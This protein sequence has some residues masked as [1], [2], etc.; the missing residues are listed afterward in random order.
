MNNRKKPCAQSYLEALR[1][2]L[3]TEP[4]AHQWET[5]VRSWDAS[6]YAFFLEMGTGKSKILLDSIR[7]LSLHRDLDGALIVAPKGTYANWI[8][9]EI[10]RHLDGTDVRAVLWQG[11]G[12]K[13]RREELASIM[14][15]TTSVRL[16]V[17]NTEA[18]STK[19]GQ[20]VADAFLRSCRRPLMA[21]DE[22]TAIKNPQ[23]RRTKAAI[24]LG[25]KAEWTR[26]MTGS[27]VTKS[28]LD[29]YAQCEFLRAQMLGS[30]SF[31]TF[32]N[33]YAVMARRSIGGRSFQEITGYRNTEE[34]TQRLEAFSTRL[35]KEECLDLP[36]KV[37]TSRE[38]EL[39]V[40]QRRHYDA[41][42]TFALTALDGDVVTA[43]AVITQLLR[44]HQ[45]VCG[46]LP[47][48]D[49]DTVEEIP[50]N[51]VST[52]LDVIEETSGKVIIWANYRHDIKSVADALAKAHGPRSVATYFGD[53]SVDDRQDA[54]ERFQDP[55]DELRFFVGQG[56]TG[57][58]GLTLTA[59]NTVVYYSNS[60]D[61]EVRLQS[62]DR[63]HR[64]GQQK[65]VTYVDLIAPGTV[66]AK[67]VKALREK[68]DIATEVLG[69]GW[70]EWLVN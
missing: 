34:L 40:E 22:S 56:R 65:S 30:S 44:L 5:L 14:E 43:P 18:L 6:E 53:T 69:D 48:P 31:Y 1:A 61:L 26:I 42:Q 68:I 51:R 13:A 4:Y 24:K 33:R 2:S 10:P 64:I 58:Y 9:Q 23:A 11:D 12:T 16:F 38:V 20:V 67:I 8:K 66:D 55:D 37:Y 45:V 50:N 29:L 41:L 21:I 39:T 70:R 57:G 25:R 35:L 46:H 28:P 15:E 49:S 36:P 59:A 47:L 54:V 32:R 17:L 63:A 60:Y 52:L 27:P 3:C 19:K 7:L 62:E